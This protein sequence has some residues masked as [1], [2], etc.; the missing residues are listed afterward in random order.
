MQPQRIR[1]R[2]ILGQSGLA[3]GGAYLALTLEGSSQQ[4]AHA[5]IPRNG[6]TRAS[7]LEFVSVVLAFQLGAISVSS[8]GEGSTL[9][10]GWAMRQFPRWAV[11]PEQGRS[12]ISDSGR[13]YAVGLVL[14]CSLVCMATSLLSPSDPPVAASS[15]DQGLCKPIMKPRETRCC[16]GQ[17]RCNA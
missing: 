1:P 14:R 17:I 12:S 8:P 16:G 2:A 10:A 9:G 5:A 4:K 11:F 7:T 3:V 6:S 13:V 15:Q